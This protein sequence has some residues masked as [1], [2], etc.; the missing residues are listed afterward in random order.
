M[1]VLII[2]VSPTCAHV[3]FSGKASV[4]PLSSILS[5]VALRRRPLF[6]LGRVLLSHFLISASIRHNERRRRRSKLQPIRFT[7]RQTPLGEY[8]HSNKCRIRCATRSKF[9]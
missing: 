1:L 7:N 8:H 3:F 9:Q 2:G 5:H 4:K 6:A